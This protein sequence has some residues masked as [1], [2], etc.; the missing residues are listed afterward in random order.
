MTAGIL[1]SLLRPTFLVPYRPTLQIRTFYTLLKFPINLRFPPTP[2]HV[3]AFSSQ[4]YQTVSHNPE[5]NKRYKFSQTIRSSRLLWHH[6][7]NKE[8]LNNIPYTR[9]SWR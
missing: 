9:I 2:G 4:R 1:I 8:E 6:L 3:K 5:L 7:T